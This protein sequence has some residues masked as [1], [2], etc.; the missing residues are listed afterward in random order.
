MRLKR[1]GFGFRAKAGKAAVAATLARVDS[2]GALSRFKLVQRDRRFG[3]NSDLNLTWLWAI[4]A[5]GSRLVYDQVFGLA[6]D[7]WRAVFF[8]E[9]HGYGFVGGFWKL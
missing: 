3:C 1:L 8:R 4:V 9:G 7:A 6:G 2:C 5:N